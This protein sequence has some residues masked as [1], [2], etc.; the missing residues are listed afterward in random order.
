MKEFDNLGAGS[1]FNTPQPYNNKFKGILTQKMTETSKKNQT[2]ESQNQS[3]IERLYD[4]KLKEFLKIRDRMIQSKQLSSTKDL[5]LE[6]IL[7]S[8]I[9][10]DQD[11]SSKQNTA[12]LNKF[13]KGTTNKVFETERTS[14]IASPPSMRSLG[15]ISDEYMGVP[16][17][18]SSIALCRTLSVSSS[19]DEILERIKSLFSNFSINFSL[20]LPFSL[21]YSCCCEY[22][23][24]CIGLPLNVE[25]NGCG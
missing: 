18:S 8:A 6:E 22:C 17:K 23:S 3:E 15:V 14:K 10:S 20:T 4:Q 9:K 16:V 19:S 5:N 25:K 11:L 13:L 2:P 21:I 24:Y 12:E 7:R 1:E